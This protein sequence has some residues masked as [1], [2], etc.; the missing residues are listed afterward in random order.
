VHP[1]LG[2]RRHFQAFFYASAFFQSDGVPPPAP[3]RVTQTVGQI[4]SFKEKGEY[5]MFNRIFNPVQGYKSSRN[6]DGLFK[7][8]RD[9][10]LQQEAANA[11]DEIGQGY[12]WQLEAAALQDNDEFVRQ[13]AKKNYNAYF[14]RIDREEIK[15]ALQK[16]EGSAALLVNIGLA[17]AHLLGLKKDG[18]ES[19][20]DIDFL[21]TVYEVSNGE[22]DKLIHNAA[23]KVLQRIK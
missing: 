3:A 20:D 5:V 11:I 15:Q 9:K 17:E 18:Q 13:W 19:Q 14:H 4:K 2:I 10:K 1:T 6:F 8:L 22:M 12:S 7:L 23:E 21:N 16:V